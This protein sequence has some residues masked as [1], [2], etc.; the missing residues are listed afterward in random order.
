MVTATEDLAERIVRQPLE[1]TKAEV[2]QVLRTIYGDSVTEIVDI[3]FPDWSIDPFFFGM[4]TNKPVGADE[5]SHEALAAP[6]G[7]LYFSG[8][9]THPRYSGFIHGGYLAG[10]ATAEA[11][12]DEIGEPNSPT[13]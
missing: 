13:T 2:T 3:I 9:T 8:E 1:V 7:R 4:Y 5:E 6:L 10:I 12:L 11:I